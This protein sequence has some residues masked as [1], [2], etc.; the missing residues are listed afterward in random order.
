MSCGAWEF[1]LQNDRR[2]ELLFLY[3]TYY[4]C[5]YGCLLIDVV[6]V[7]GVSN[8]L[9]DRNLYCSKNSNIFSSHNLIPFLIFSSLVFDFL[10]E[11][12]YIS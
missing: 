2:E 11:E 4:V 8:E 1:S 10:H 6:L 12:A 7:F 9:L 5:L 3:Y